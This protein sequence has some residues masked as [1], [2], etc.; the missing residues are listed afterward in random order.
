MKYGPTE[1]VGVTN[2]KYGVPEG[3]VMGAQSLGTPTM[4]IWLE[5]TYTESLSMGS[6][7]LEGGDVERR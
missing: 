3:L 4:S 5:S 2:S 7:L 6:D 1:K